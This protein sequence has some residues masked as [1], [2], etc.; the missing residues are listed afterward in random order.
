[1]MFGRR[2]LATTTACALLGGAVLWWG[3]DGLTAF[4]AESA[5]RRAV[6]AEPRPL[7]AVA[8]EDQDGRPL[9]FAD[10]AGRRL[11]VEFIYTRCDS[12]CYSLGAAFRQIGE[13]LPGGD[14]ALLSISFDPAHDDPAR[15][16]EYGERFGADG[17][18]WRIARPRSGDDLAALLAA[19][20][21]VVVADEIGGFEHNAAIH[22][23]GDD[24][25]LRQISDLDAVDAFVAGLADDA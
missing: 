19:F 24:G 1:M 2:A 16:R 25:R 12:V 23:V 20:G 18:R 14:P 6:L 17:K 22:L 3:S 15:L 13:R 5:R 7:P 8:L 4:T 10:Y 9:A 11:A 21:V